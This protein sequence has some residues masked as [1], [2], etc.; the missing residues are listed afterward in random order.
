MH[1]KFALFTTASLLAALLACSTG[2]GSGGSSVPASSITPAVA[3]TVTTI[4]PA[5]GATCV[6]T[7]AVIQITFSG[8]A[9]PAMVN[10]TNIQVA[11]S[12]N[13]AIP[14]AVTYNA[15]TDVG[16]FTP[17]VALAS[18]E[19]FTVTVSSVKSSAGVVMQ[20]PF[21]AKFTSGPCTAQYESSLSSSWAGSINNGQ[22]SVDSNGIVTVELS[23]ATAS[24]AF[25]VQFCPY[26]RDTTCF[27]VG[28]VSS[29]SSGNATTTMAFPKS[30][31]WAGVFELEDSSGTVCYATFATHENGRGVPA[32][33]SQ[34]YMAR[35][36]PYNLF[37]G[38][39][40]GWQQDPLSSGSVTL[41]PS[42]LFQFQLSG[43]APNT[44]YSAD[45]C[46]LSMGF[47]MGTLWSPANCDTL[48]DSQTF[49]S[50]S[51]KF[52]T[53]DNGNVTF[54]VLPDA[55]PYGSVFE[56]GSPSIGSQQFVG[57]FLVP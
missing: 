41:L 50:N 15:M 2:C 14:G 27:N 21:T 49:I 42:G 37:P 47:F 9:N 24:T 16:T 46:P 4:L 10:S 48:F 18:N 45:Y 52:T 39:L 32:I 44:I 7:N 6:A 20:T 54:S 19:T 28:T 55:S 1:R 57:G 34:V 30:G 12:G 23:G 35:L 53:D 13:S 17:S 11:G 29:D 31:N 43:A 5:T 40:Q 36:Q 8:A 26:S 38:G 3:F 25:T 51:D 33:P 56:I 22:V